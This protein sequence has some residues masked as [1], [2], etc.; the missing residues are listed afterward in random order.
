MASIMTEEAVIILKV[1]YPNSF[2]SELL[3]T[4]MFI[5]QVDNKIADAAEAMND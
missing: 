2:H 4:K 3:K 5:I 1:I